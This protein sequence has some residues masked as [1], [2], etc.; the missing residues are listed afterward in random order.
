MTVLVVVVGARRLGLLAVSWRRRERRA[1][2]LAS[3]WWW[4]VLGECEEWKKSGG[5][6]DGAGEEERAACRRE[7]WWGVSA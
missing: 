1:E 7:S 6:G 3:L 4:R 2:V 5:C